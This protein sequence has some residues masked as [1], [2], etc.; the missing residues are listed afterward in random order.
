[1][2]KARLCWLFVDWRRCWKLER[3]A[4]CST[5]SRGAGAVFSSVDGDIQLGLA[6]LL[7]RW[8]KLRSI[9]A[10]LDL[11]RKKT[12]YGVIL[13][14]FLS[15]PLSCL[16]FQMQIS[17]LLPRGRHWKQSNIISQKRMWHSMQVRLDHGIE[18]I[19]SSWRLTGWFCPYVQRTW[20]ALEIKGIP[21]RQF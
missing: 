10:H 21:Y 17:I 3:G 20:L 12:S 9:F 1:M 18:F 11:C 13:Y 19:E 8:G 16:G 5:F 15:I 6:T 4:S 7:L 14:N 2:T